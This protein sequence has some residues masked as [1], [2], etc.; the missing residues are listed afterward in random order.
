[1]ARYLKIEDNKAKDITEEL[2]TKLFVD[3]GDPASIM[4]QELA[5][6]VILLKS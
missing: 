6:A 3:V 1:M 5:D 2:K 4:R